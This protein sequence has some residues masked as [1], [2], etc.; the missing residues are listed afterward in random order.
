MKLC[1]DEICVAGSSPHWTAVF[2]DWVA[3][4]QGWCAEGACTGIVA[5]T[6]HVWLLWMQVWCR[7]SLNLTSELNGSTVGLHDLSLSTPSWLVSSVVCLNVSTVGIHGYGINL[8]WYPVS[9]IFTVY[10]TSVNLCRFSVQK[11]I[12]IGQHLLSYF[13]IS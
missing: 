12:D 3:L 1:V 4:S 5:G 6:Q 11:I 13:K 8:S 2:C 7:C 10:C 9:C